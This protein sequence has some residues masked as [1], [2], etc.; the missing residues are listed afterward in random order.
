MLRRSLHPLLAL[1]AILGVL[2]GSVS[3]AHAKS[4]RPVAEP[5]RLEVPGYPDAFYYRPRGRGMK[6][7]LVY[8]HGRGGNPAEDCR[9]WARVGTQFGWVVCPS[10]PEDRGGGARAWSNNAQLGGQIV[11]AALDSLRDKFHHRVQLRNNVLIGFSEGAF[12]AMQV[13]LRDPR[14]WSHWLILAA[15]DQ[16]W[17]GDAKDVLH[18]N[19]RRIRAVYLL[20][21]ESDE[22]APNTQRVGELLKD[23][24]V[25]V[26]VKIAPGMGHEVPAERMRSTYRRPLAWLLAHR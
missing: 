6:P 24:K 26:K 8:L 14:T 13:G 25:H 15:N 20:T 4:A 10:G 1:A 3:V 2:L 19:R 5:Q 9:K 7:V 21:G 11:K 22:V 16:Y 17:F 18:E 23:E 12:V